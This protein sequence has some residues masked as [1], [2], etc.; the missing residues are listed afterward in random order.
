MGALGKSERDWIRTLPLSLEETDYQLVHASTAAEQYARYI[1]T[2]EEAAAAFA[3]AKRPWVFHGHTH[4]PMA[5]FK[6][7]PLSYNKGP[8]WK[9]AKNVPALLNV[10]S[11]GQPRDKDPRASYAIFD[12]DKLEV[13]LRRV[14]YDCQKA[15]ASIRAA[16]L[17]EKLAARLT[18]GS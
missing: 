15:V 4:V 7:D 3:A 14:E 6:T 9:L 12:S 1:L 8:D 17:P 16:G 13:R 18:T 10:G 2:M 11:V 5:F